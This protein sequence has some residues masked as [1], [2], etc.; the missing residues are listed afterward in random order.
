[1]QGRTS[2]PRSPALG[3]P[4]QTPNDGARRQMPKSLRSHAA[5]R[6]IPYAY[7]TAGSFTAVIEACC[8]TFDQINNPF[9]YRI[10]TLV[11]VGSGNSSPQSTLP[12]L[13]LC[14]PSG[15]C[16][17]TVPAIDPDGDTLQFRL[18]TPAEAGGSF[19]SIQP[20]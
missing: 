18:S 1:M 8:R 11:N 14:P 7:A 2:P 20:G 17:F 3:R 15:L 4:T 13:V 6:T 10:E 9:E 16:V 19:G 12:P 5:S